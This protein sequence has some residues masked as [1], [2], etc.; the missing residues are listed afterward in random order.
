M[1][2]VLAGIFDYLSSPPVRPQAFYSACG[3]TLSPQL[4]RD[5]SAGRA[6]GNWQEAAALLRDILGFR[7][8]GRILQPET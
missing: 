7:V 2:T 5:I 6:K 4:S 8:N 3:R 1:L